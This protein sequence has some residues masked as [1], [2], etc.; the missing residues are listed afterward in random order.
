M[1]KIIPWQQKQKNVR[2]ILTHVEMIELDIDRCHLFW[3]VGSHV[4][5]VL[6]KNMRILNTFYNYIVWRHGHFLCRHYSTCDDILSLLYPHWTSYCVIPDDFTIVP[7]FLFVAYEFI[8]VTLIFSFD[9]QFTATSVGEKN[10]IYYNFLFFSQKS[11]P[12]FW[13][14]SVWPLWKLNK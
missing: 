9:S 7:F 11:P 3:L 10:R 6:F 5:T 13:K 12:R 14:I 4:Y 2:Y 8:R 1:F